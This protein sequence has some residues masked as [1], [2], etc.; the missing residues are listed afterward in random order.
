MGIRKEIQRLEAE[1]LREKET[2]KQERVSICERIS[3][4]IDFLN[5]QAR[6]LIRPYFQ[7]LLQSGVG[8]VL[9]ELREAVELKEEVQF[10]AEISYLGP[11]ERKAAPISDGKERRYEESVCFAGE[12]LRASNPS[13]LANAFFGATEEEEYS[14]RCDEVSSLLKDRDGRMVRSND[15]ESLARDRDSWNEVLNRLLFIEP[16]HLRVEDCFVALK[17]L[18]WHYYTGYGEGSQKVE[19]TRWLLFYPIESGKAV[20]LKKSYQFPRGLKE[21]CSDSDFD[22]FS[23]P[24]REWENRGLLERKVAEAYYALKKERSRR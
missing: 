23:F 21:F 8:D 6:V 18:S 16:R 12:D 14:F 15:F 22:L 5:E 17:C 11:L 7:P 3:E 10:G 24:K 1:G 9:R 2:I 19:E 4:R 13:F 20:M